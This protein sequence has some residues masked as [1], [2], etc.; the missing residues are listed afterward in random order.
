MR[1]LHTVYL[2]G[3]LLST[4]SFAREQAALPAI[5]WKYLQKSKP[6]ERTEEWRVIPQV[7]FNRA[8][9]PSDAFILFGGYK[10][11]QWQQA[12]FP[13]AANMEQARVIAEGL[14]VHYKGAPAPWVVKVDRFEMKPG[15]GPIATKQAFGSVQLHMEWKVPIQPEKT[16]QNYGNSGIFFMGLYEI[17]ILNSHKNTTYANGQAASLYKQKAPDVNASTAPG[18]WQI[19]DIVFTAPVFDEN[20]NIMTPAYVTLIHNGVLVQNHVP[21]KGPTLYMDESQYIF[22]PPKLPIVLQDHGE[23]IQFR[24]IWL[25]ELN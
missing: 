3:L 12:Q 20:R 6:W 19:Y 14:D 11:D 22:H 15:A 18:T 10:L 16:G 7:T 4:L 23:P 1:P 8:E 21:L 2:I 17:Q 24:N 13:L 5:D 25:R 9:V